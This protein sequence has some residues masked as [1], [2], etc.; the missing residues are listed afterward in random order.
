MS[1]VKCK[2][3]GCNKMFDPDQNNEESCCFH[4]MGPIFHEG[5]KGWGCCSKRVIEFNDFLNIPG[6]TTGK[7][8]TIEV[9]EEK[10]ESTPTTLAGVPTRSENIVVNENINK[11]TEFFSFQHSDVNKEKES[12]NKI[13]EEDLNDI[14][15]AKIGVGTKCKRKGCNAVFNGEESREEECHFHPGDPIFHEG[16]KGY[17]CCSRK[18]LE[19]DEFLKIKGCKLGKHRFTEPQVVQQKE[20]KIDIKHDW[21]Q[22]QTHIIVSLFAK[23]ADKENTVISFTQNSFTASIKFQDGRSTVYEANLFDCIDEENSRYSI[24]GT[25]IEL[26]LKKKS[27]IS[28]PTLNPSANVTSFTTF[29]VSG[30]TGTI[31]SKEMVYNNDIPLN[32]LSR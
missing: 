27:G 5:M 26:S 1:L 8:S 17:T 14:K 12:K 25:K 28:W 24:L 23:K 13:K 32:S 18:V 30:T 20:E 3:R 21:Y 4:T 31:G 9:A 29:G 22:T 15:D 11:N 16:S 19:F 10:K 6:C 2:N 7:H